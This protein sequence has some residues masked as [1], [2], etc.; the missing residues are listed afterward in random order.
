MFRKSRKDAIVTEEDDKKTEESNIKQALAQC[1]Y[2][3]WSID[4][5]KAQKQQPMT[6]NKNTKPN[7]AKMNKNTKPNKAKS[8]G[9]VVIPYVEDVIERLSRIFKKHGFSTQ[10]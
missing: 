9:M 5:V 3:E 4:K 10:G 7:K 8:K 2:P 1:G 6:M